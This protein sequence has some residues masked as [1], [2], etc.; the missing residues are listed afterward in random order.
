VISHPNPLESGGR[1]GG[2]RGGGAGATPWRQPQV[3]LGGK[4]RK[5][6][7][8]KGVR[9][10]R[11]PPEYLSESR[12]A[13]W[14]DS[15]LSRARACGATHWPPQQHRPAPGRRGALVAP[16]ALAR[17]SEESRHAAWH[18]QKGYFFAI[19]VGPGLFLIN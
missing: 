4:G 14:R 15:L 6:R 5:G 7:R 17:L 13:A 9:V 1:G 10:V 19:L 12:Q 2:S 18:D 11:W 3:R 8:R 16:H